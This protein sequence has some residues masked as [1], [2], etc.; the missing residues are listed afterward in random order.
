MRKLY[1]PPMSGRW[2]GDDRG[3][4]IGDAEQL[5]PG[6]SEL[7]AAFSESEWV[8][9]LPE[10]HLRPHVEEWCKQDGRLTL[11]D[12]VVDDRDAYVLELKWIGEPAGVGQVR[13]AVFSLVGSFA[14]S[15]T[16]VRQR[17]VQRDP[18]SS[19]VSLRFEVGTGELASEARFHP[20]GHTLVIN[21]A[22]VV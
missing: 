3:R 5:V 16:Y 7:V 14:E 21:V 1:R 15:A 6:A 9:E 20:H 2:D 17:T 11:T 18:D 10:H 19:A 22:G 13:A 4:G 8:A 12:A